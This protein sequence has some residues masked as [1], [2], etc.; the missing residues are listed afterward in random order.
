MGN[1]TMT[2]KTHLDR[3]KTPAQPECACS[4]FPQRSA[5]ARFIGGE[6][7]RRPFPPTIT[8]S[9]IPSRFRKPI[10]RSWSSS[11]ADAAD[12]P[13]PQRDDVRGLARTWVNEGT[14]AIIADVPVNTPNAR[15][16]ASAWREIR[17]QLVAGGV[18]SSAITPCA[19]TRP[20][21]PRRLC[22]DPAELSEDHGGGRPLRPVARRPRPQHRQPLLQREQAVPQFRLRL[23]AQPRRHGRQSGRPRAA[24]RRDPRL[25]GAARHRVHPYRKGKPTTTVYPEQD[26]AKLSDTGK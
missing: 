24:A 17:S 26:K 11:A 14:G 2:G 6:S 13:L 5:P 20:D 3:L 25:Y 8:A 7:S 12:C 10:A 18:P 16:A 19:T 4:P 15:A 21:D 22:G 1:E 9:A 23:A